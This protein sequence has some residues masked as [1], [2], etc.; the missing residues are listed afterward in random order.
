MS[1]KRSIIERILKENQFLKER[2]S[3]LD[4]DLSFS[5]MSVIQFLEKYHSTHP[6][7]TS[8]FLENGSELLFHESPK[9]EGHDLNYF[10]SMLI[11]VYDVSMKDGVTSIH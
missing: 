11:H 4:M 9:V 7:L 2:G 6:H 1:K 3:T 10:K 8:G 5:R